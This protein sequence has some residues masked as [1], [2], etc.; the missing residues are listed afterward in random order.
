MN[1]KKQESL[2]LAEKCQLY[3]SSIPRYQGYDWITELYFGNLIANLPSVNGCIELQV[4]ALHTYICTFT[5]N[6]N[7]FL[8]AYVRKIR[9]AA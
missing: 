2:L 6:L 9:V 8:P 7:L 3:S 1:F 4:L 5:T